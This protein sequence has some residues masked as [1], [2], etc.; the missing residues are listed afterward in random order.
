MTDAE[1]SAYLLQWCDKPHLHP[2]AWPTDS[3]GYTQH[4]RFVRH[5]NQNWTGGAPSDF[6]EF[7]RQYAL[8]LVVSAGEEKC[9]FE[10]W[11]GQ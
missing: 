6:V 7:V 11:R 1:T 10:E 2:F 4:I 9:D 5:R 8:T 3:C